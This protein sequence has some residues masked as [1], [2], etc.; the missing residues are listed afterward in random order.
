MIALVTAALRSGDTD[1]SI[2]KE[3]LTIR[4]SEVKQYASEMERG[5]RFIVQN[6][7][8]EDDIR[9]AH[10]D[11]NADYGTITNTAQFQLFN[12]EGGGVA[13]RQPPKGI[14]T[15]AG[16]QWEFYGHTHAPYMG[17]NGAPKADLIAVLPNVTK[18]FCEKINEMDGFQTTTQPADPGGFGDNCVKSTDSMRFDDTTQYDDPPNEM[19]QTTFL[20]AATGAEKPAPE[21]CVTCTS[22]GS[23]T[24][25]FYHV[26][27]SR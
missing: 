22:A 25:N 13:Y 20:D 9:F 17:S 11:A 5:V 4:A 3:N 2:D 21:A 24:Y 23:T 18:A 6:G 16:G 27:Y 12:R 26:L 14:Q 19:D 1:A 8:S 10:P 15:A 7:A